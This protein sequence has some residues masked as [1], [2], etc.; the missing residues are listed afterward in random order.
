[1]YKKGY[2]NLPWYFKMPYFT[3]KLFS[4]FVDITNE[5][6]VMNPSTFKSHIDERQENETL[7]K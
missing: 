2:E 4:N 3:K 5:L 6:K 7:V 1:M